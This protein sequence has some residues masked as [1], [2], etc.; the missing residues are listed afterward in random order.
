MTVEI[1]APQ[2]DKLILNPRAPMMSERVLHAA[3]NSRS[4]PIQAKLYLYRNDYS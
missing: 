3:A 1:G 4:A 2:I